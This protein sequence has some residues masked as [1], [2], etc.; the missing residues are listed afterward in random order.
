MHT[1]RRLKVSPLISQELPRGF[2]FAVFTA[3]PRRYSVDLRALQQ[4]NLKSGYK[5]CVRRTVASDAA[6]PSAPD[7]GSIETYSRPVHRRRGL[8][9]PM[10][11]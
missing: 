10:L 8:Q 9:E 4:R 11:Q 1:R 3:A 2:D 5:R 6:A 7:V